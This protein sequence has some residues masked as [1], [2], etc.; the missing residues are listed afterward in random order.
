M[1][2]SIPVHTD[3]KIATYGDPDL[4]APGPP[5]LG[6]DC[7][8]LT[9]LQH[10]NR[11][12]NYRIPH[13]SMTADPGMPYRELRLHICRHPVLDTPDQRHWE[14]DYG[15]YFTAYG[16][17]RARTGIN[18]RGLLIESWVHR[19]WFLK[20]P[21]IPLD[22]RIRTTLGL[23]PQPEEGFPDVSAA[24]PGFRLTDVYWHK[25]TLT[26]RV[27]QGKRAAEPPPGAPAPQRPQPQQHQQQ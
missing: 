12:A 1:F 17:R 7:V 3:W 15:D 6:I 26:G 11:M 23:P 4:T 24:P 19:G 22:K 2:P 5:H 20:S 9:N 16:L 14:G 25:D 18:E 27:M 10:G 21:Y 13:P 8:E